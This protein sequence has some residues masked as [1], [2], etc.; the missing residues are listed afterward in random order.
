MYCS[1]TLFLCC[2]VVVKNE[3]YDTPK[4]NED[5]DTNFKNKLIGR[6]ISIF[7]S[8]SCFYRSSCCVVS[9][10]GYLISFW[11]FKMVDLKFEW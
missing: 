7:L 4:K 6:Y 1:L 10:S 8:Q 2:S 5:Y 3:D 11:S 9:N